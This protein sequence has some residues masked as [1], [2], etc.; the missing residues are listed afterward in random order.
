MNLKLAVQTLKADQLE[1]GI[2]KHIDVQLAFKRQNIAVSLKKQILT[3]PNALAPSAASR[4]PMPDILN[5]FF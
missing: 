3:M 4:M 1:K 5:V 2:L